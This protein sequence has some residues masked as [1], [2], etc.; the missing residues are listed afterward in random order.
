MK[1]RLKNKQEFTKVFK[2]YITW[3]LDNTVKLS[4]ILTFE[5]FNYLEVDEQTSL[6][7]SYWF[8]NIR[9]KEE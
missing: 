2:D 3:A 1:I 5:S 9:G 7:F 8:V 4:T 6:V